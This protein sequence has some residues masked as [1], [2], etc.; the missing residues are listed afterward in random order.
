MILHFMPQTGLI[1]I[2]VGATSLL[3]PVIGLAATPALTPVATDQKE[4]WREHLKL[5]AEYEWRRLQL[6][7]FD[8]SREEERFNQDRFELTLAPGVSMVFIKVPAGAYTEG[9]S[10]EQVAMLVG[11]PNRRNDSTRWRDMYPEGVRRQVTLDYDFFMSEVLITNAMF[12][13]FVDQTDYVTSVS[14]YRTGWIVDEKATWRQGIGND[15]TQPPL[16]VAH[17]EHPVVQVS[18]YDAMFFAHWLSAKFGVVF[19]PPTKDEWLL[20][21][22]PPSMAGQQV[23]FPWGNSVELAPKRANFGTRELK[24][25]EWIHEQFSDG[26]AYTSPV[27]AFPPNERGLHDMV[28]NIWS[29]NFQ[30]QVMDGDRRPGDEAEG[31]G[32]ARTGVVPPLESLGAQENASITMQGGCYLARIAHTAMFAK[33]SH[34]AL[35][36]AEDIGIRLVAVRVANSGLKNVLRR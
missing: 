24:D 31:G 12:K 7:S 25:Y 14:R 5:C 34:P 28:G 3:A 30:R 23:C 20:A 19:R 2:L 21:A 22:Y 17:A 11:V 8:A 18:W 33:M 1:L 9:L 27:K 16:G 10:P 13:A 29:W 26:Y 4:K 35:D 6:Q 36:G 15:W 32:T